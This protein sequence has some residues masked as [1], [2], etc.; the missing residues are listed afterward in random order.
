MKA[1]ESSQHYASKLRE[2]TNFTVR[3][4]KKVSNDI[5]AREMGSE[6]EKKTQDYIKG[7]ME[8]VA[9]D[10][11][12]QSFE[13]A[14]KALLSVHKIDGIL[15]I[16]SAIFAIMSTLNFIS[17]SKIIFSSIAVILAVITLII[18]FGEFVMQKG[19]I[20]FAF[21]KA[22]SD[23]LVF[24]RKASRETKKRIVFTGYT[25]SAYESIYT[26]AFLAIIDIL[27][28]VFFALLFVTEI[29]SFFELILPI[30]IVLVVIQGLSILAFAL[31][32]FYYN[33]KMPI[34]GSNNL[35]GAFSSMAVMRYMAVN[36]VRF[37]NTEVV[38]VALS[39]NT[40]GYKGAK[41][42][43]SDLK[44]D[45][46]ETLYIDVDTLAD[47]DEFSVSGNASDI[48]L[49]AAKT[50]D[51]KAFSK[52]NN[53]GAVVAEKMGLNAACLS[54]VDKK[55]DTYNTMNDKADKVDAKA[56]E[57]GINILLETAFEFDNK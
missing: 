29:A 48:L 46:I 8:R 11:K 5:G 33:F 26:N 41:A 54:A 20:D 57:C 13:Y 27:A 42:L 44:K 37:E 35:T 32:I 28:K 50:A 52:K 53:S 14:P 12:L 55:S 45:N 1:S 15:M 31:I 30:K 24:T 16:V 22:K 56:V 19:I 18:Y 23:N 40:A 7:S 38:A 3:E 51:V 43:F 10:I 4:I 9:D 34:I 21:K 2:C 17:G 36:D 39:G 47:A 6:A 25:D 49:T